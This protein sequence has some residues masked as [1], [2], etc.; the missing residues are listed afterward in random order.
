MSE[1]TSDLSKEA[2]A[3][4]LCEHGTAKL[5][6]VKEFGAF[7]VSLWDIPDEEVKSCDKGFAVKFVVPPGDT[8]YPYPGHEPMVDDM[9][10][11]LLWAVARCVKFRWINED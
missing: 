2:E 7:T 1:L 8:A 6:E 10:A 11:G 3:K 4:C 5:H 9:L